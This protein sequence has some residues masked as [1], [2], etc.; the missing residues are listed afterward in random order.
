LTLKNGKVVALLTFKNERFNIPGFMDNLSSIA[1][2]IIGIDYE[3]TDLSADVFVSWGG[4]LLDYE[5]SRDWADGGEYLARE[6]LLK[7]GIR[8]G[9]EFFIVLDADER[10]SSN[11]RK[12][13]IYDLEPGSAL[14][15]WWVNLV[16]TKRYISE[17]T[18]FG[19]KYKDFVFRKK[20][21]V[22]YPFAKLHVSRTPFGFEDE[23]W[24]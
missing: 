2:L 6:N 23:T 12:E 19:P 8:M 14:G 7:E 22:G 9:G 17:G 5:I 24:E 18:Y 3:S 1:D 10:F 15:L 16:D 20:E 13:W 11:F 4:V 21:G